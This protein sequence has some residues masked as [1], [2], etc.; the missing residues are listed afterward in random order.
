MEIES[1]AMFWRA[2]MCISMFIEIR[3]GM[4]NEKSYMIT[5]SS[6]KNKIN[7]KAPMPGL[8]PGSAR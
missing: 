2:K 1:Y 5:S 8:E 3:M 6:M 4:R 7:K